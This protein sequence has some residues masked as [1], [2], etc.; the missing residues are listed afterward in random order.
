MLDFVG[1]GGLSYDI[2]MQMERLPGADGKYDAAL[3]GLFPGGFIA[4]AVSAAARL[5]LRAGFAGWIG[6]DNGGELL[7]RAFADDGVDCRGLN[8]LKD[9][10]TPFCVIMVSGSERAIIVP[11]FSLYKQALS[12]AQLEQARRARV[13]L[14]YPRDEAWCRT[15]ADAAHEN[16]GLFALDVEATSPLRGRRLREL[17]A[18]ADV[19]FLNEDSLA[20]VE[21][22]RLEDLRGLGWVIMTAG[23]RGAYA[24]SPDQDQ[25]IFQAAYPVRAIDTTGAGDCFHAGLLAARLW[26][27]NLPDAL[28][29]ASGAAALKVQHQGARGGQP[30]REQVES[31]LETWT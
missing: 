20:A 4:N 8:V 29:F 27:K 10:A 15:L 7:Q 5:G 11:S 16:G 1:V 19:I 12:E 31:L 17:L 28:R 6:E 2:V 23:A 22:D 13:V 9:E 3:A 30:A 26:G 24:L 18:L 14:T 21:A 25:V